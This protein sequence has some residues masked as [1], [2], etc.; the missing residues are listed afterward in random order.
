M[1]ITLLARRIP[2]SNAV[3]DF[4]FRPSDVGAVS[5][6]RSLHFR[7]TSGRNGMSFRIACP[8]GVTARWWAWSCIWASES[9]VV[10]V[11]TQLAEAGAL[12]PVP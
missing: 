12:T 2:P 4:K 9:A 10:A 11:R 6:Q 3:D 5:Q 1:T 8:P 7:G